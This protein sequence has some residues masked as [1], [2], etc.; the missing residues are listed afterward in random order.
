MDGYLAVRAR[1]CLAL[2]IAVCGFELYT[3]GFGILSP[4][5]QRATLLLFAAVLAF[6]QFPTAHWPERNDLPGWRRAAAI[7]WDVAVIAT[8]LATCLFLILEEDALADRS[9]AETTLDLAMAAAGPIMLLEMV[10][11]VVGLPLFF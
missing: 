2:A 7:L 4:L 9:G 6:L 8:A 5:T 3:V 10:R 1:L 11:R